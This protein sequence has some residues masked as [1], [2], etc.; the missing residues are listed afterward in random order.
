[1]KYLLIY[2]CLI[3]II[4]V[5]IGLYTINYKISEPFTPGIRKIYRPYIRNSRIFYQNTYNKY[6]QHTSNLFKKFG[7]I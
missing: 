7:I 5:N 4:L 2:F 1:M 6:R 3:I